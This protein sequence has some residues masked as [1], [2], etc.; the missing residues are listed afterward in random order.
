MDAIIESVASIDDL[1][2]EGE[3]IRFRSELEYVYKINLPAGIPLPRAF[4]L[5]LNKINS[6]AQ[7]NLSCT[8]NGNI[9]TGLFAFNSGIRP[10]LSC[11]TN[12]TRIKRLSFFFYDR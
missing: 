5:W 11:L 2:L 8:L 7:E 1:F 12:I 9:A 10:L 4:R 6:E 3:E